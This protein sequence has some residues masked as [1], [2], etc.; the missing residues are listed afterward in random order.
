[1][2]FFENQSRA[3]LRGM[4]VA[5]WRK[6]L[7]GLPIEPLEAQI[8]AVIAEHP[9]YHSLLSDRDAALAKDFT[10]ENGQNNPFLHMAMHLAVRDQVATDRPVGIRQIFTTLQRRRD[11]LDVEHA[12]AEHLA[13]MIWQSQRSG[14]PPDEQVYLRRVQ[15]LLR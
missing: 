15:K 1:M 10:P 5:A 9:E 13:E 3:D 12:I 7:A 11:K 2:P 4:Y 14:L 6:H 8:I